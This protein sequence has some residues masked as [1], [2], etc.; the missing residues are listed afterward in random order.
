MSGMID[1][2][3]HHVTKKH[4]ETPDASCAI[5]KSHQELEAM[6]KDQLIALVELLKRELELAYTRN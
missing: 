6:S 5:C 4:H 1:A 2:L 3:T